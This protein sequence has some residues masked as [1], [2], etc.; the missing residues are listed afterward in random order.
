VLAA[1]LRARQP[2][3]AQQLPQRP[4]CGCRGAT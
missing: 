2:P 3:A 4:L 1:K